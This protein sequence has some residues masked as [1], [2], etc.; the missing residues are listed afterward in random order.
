[1]NEHVSD[2]RQIFP[3]FWAITQSGNFVSFGGCAKKEFCLDRCCGGCEA[4]ELHM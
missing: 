2:G 1:V 4:R 3:S